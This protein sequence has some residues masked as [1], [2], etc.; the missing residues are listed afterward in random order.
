MIPVVTRE[1]ILRQRD[2]NPGLTLVEALDPMLYA[3][4]HLPG[5]VNVP[6]DSIDAAAAAALPD[7]NAAI[8]VYCASHTCASSHRVAER[9]I[10]LGYTRIA[11]YQ[12]GK[13]DWIAAGLPVEYGRAGAAVSR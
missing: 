10:Q 12:N 8:V 5:A 2:T 1:D 13:Q 7:K 4:V 6:P 9:L 11:H 3:A